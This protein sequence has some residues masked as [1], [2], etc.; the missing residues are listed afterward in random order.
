M[1]TPLIFV[2]NGAT[3][4]ECE[5]RVSFYAPLAQHFQV[6]CVEAYI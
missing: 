6:D 3:G 1:Y 2:T 5:K 4:G